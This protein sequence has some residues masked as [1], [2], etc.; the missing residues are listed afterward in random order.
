MKDNLREEI[1]FHFPIFGTQYKT[2]Y[3]NGFPYVPLV[4][5]PGAVFLIS[6]R[7]EFN[8]SDKVMETVLTSWTFIVVLILLSYFVGLIM[9]L[10][11]SWHL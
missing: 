5:S 7:N 6:S 4:H 9:W 8:E 3:G 10:V 2:T 1:D 11:V